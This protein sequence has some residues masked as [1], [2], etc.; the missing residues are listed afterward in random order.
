[1]SEAAQRAAAAFARPVEGPS[2]RPAIKVAA[3][4]IVVVVAA[5]GGRLLF[6]QGTPSTQSLAAAGL[7]LL[8]LLWPLPGMLAGRTRIDAQGIRQQGWA[9]REVEWAQ[10]RRIRFARLPMTPRLLVSAGFGRMK[11]FYSGSPELDRAFER[12]VDVMTGPRA[13]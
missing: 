8:L 4:S 9:A 11:V 13:Q 10:V 6:Q 5:W 1:M 3:V 12:V 7:V 2:H